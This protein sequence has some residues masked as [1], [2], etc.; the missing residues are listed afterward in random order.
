MSAERCS[1]LVVDDEAYLLPTLRALLSPHYDVILAGTADEAEAILR[2]RPVDILLTDQRMPHRS[3]VQLL[4]W[5]AEHSPNTIRLLMTGFSEL[6]DAIDAINRGHIYHY[7]L[8]PWR[9][10][11][12]LQVIRNAADKFQLER[13][14]D[15]LVEQLQELNRDLELRV[16]ERTRELREANALLEQRTRELERLAMTD[17]RTGLLNLRAIEEM[18]SFELKRLFRY[19]GPVAVGYVDIDHFKDVNTEYTHSGGDEALRSLAQVL[20]GCVREVDSV[21]RV[22]GEEFMVL[23]RETGVE[24]ACVLAERIR[25]SVEQARFSYNGR[26][27]QITV[28]VGFAVAEGPT[29]QKSL[30]DLATEALKEA[31]STGRNR[32]VIRVLQPALSGASA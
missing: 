1:V 5:A 17:P 15:E 10:E 12:L 13:R 8:K 31:K 23:A 30:V 14:R 29:E 28:S 7:L 22:G 32:C 21:A 27:I 3:G 6:E 2:A 11:D 19:P 4:E 20:N 24:G 26:D 16:A 18:L 9:S 25:A